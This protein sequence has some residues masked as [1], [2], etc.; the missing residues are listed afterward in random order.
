MI[1]KRFASPV[2]LFVLLSFS[3]DND[4]DPFYT[5]EWI[6]GS[7][8]IRHI[9]YY[10]VVDP[11]CTEQDA[12]FRFVFHP[13]AFLYTEDCPNLT[14]ATPYIG[15]YEYDGRNTVTTDLGF[16]LEILDVNKSI[17]RFELRYEDEP[18]IGIF[19]Y[20]KTCDP[21]GALCTNGKTTAE[22]G[23]DACQ[24]AD[25]ATWKCG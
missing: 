18:A 10:D 5:V 11:A 1:L 14:M 23:S 13:D 8:E 17:L 20:E 22:T 15:E 19:L 24:P 21:V 4:D 25:V 2:L 9:A 7:W 3:C 12:G 6:Y 16:K